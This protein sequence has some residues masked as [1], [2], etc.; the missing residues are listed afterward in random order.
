VTLLQQHLRL[1]AI[2]SPCLC[3]RN[4]FRPLSGIAIAAARNE[5]EDFCDGISFSVAVTAAFGGVDEVCAAGVGGRDTFWCCVGEA[6]EEAVEEV[7][8]VGFDSS[9][10]G[11]GHEREG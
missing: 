10:K 4:L 5:V 8:T 6:G 1:Q 3:E 11:F 9:E 7:G 2:R